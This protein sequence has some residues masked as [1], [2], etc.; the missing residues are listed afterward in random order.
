M[1]ELRGTRIYT[2]LLGRQRIGQA[3][4]TEQAK[5]LITKWAE[6]N[7]GYLFYDQNMTREKRQE[8]RKKCLGE[9]AEE[10]FNKKTLDWSFM[11]ETVKE[12]YGGQ[13][14]EALRLIS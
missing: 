6:V 12:A 14:V 11:V 13:G 4:T 9:L 10:W 3:I 2:V 7:Y 1:R 5:E 8:I